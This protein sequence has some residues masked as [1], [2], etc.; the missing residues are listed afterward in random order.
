MAE[1]FISYKREDREWAEALSKLLESK[2]L[3][4][5]WDKRLS[6]GQD[7]DFVIDHEL[8]IADCV[9]VL[10]SIGSVKSRWV[11]AEANEGSARG[12]LV[13]VLIEDVRPPLAFRR[14]QTGSLI[15]WKKIADDVFERLYS[16]VQKVLHSF[17]ELESEKKGKYKIKPAVKD[18]SKLFEKCLSKQKK[19]IDWRTK[20]RD[21]NDPLK[22]S[23]QA[24][25]HEV[26]SRYNRMQIFGMT[27]PIS[28][29]DVF[30]DTRINEDLTWLQHHSAEQLNQITKQKAKKLDLQDVS[31]RGIKIAN[32]NKRLVVLGNPGGGTTT[33][34]IN[35]ALYTLAG[36]MEF[37][38]L[39]IFISLWS[40][41][42]AE[43]SLIDYI[44]NQ[45]DICNFPDAGYFITKMLE[46][47]NCLVLIDGYDLITDQ[48]KEIAQELRNFM[49][50][51]SEN[52]YILSSRI[53]AYDFAF[54]DFKVVEVANF[55]EK[56][57]KSYIGKW[58]AHSD[59]L[60][61]SCWRMLTNNKSLKEFVNKPLFLTLLCIAHDENFGLLDKYEELYGQAIRAILFRWDASRAIKRRTVHSN[62]SQKKVELLLGYLGEY[63]FQV[64]KLFMSQKAL[65]KKINEF[66]SKT[67]ITID[68]NP[69][70]DSLYVLKTIQ[71]NSG[72]L[73]ECA[74]NVFSFSHIALQEYFTAQYIIEEQSEKT[75][76]RENLFVPAW[77][78]V[79][80]ISAGML[81]SRSQSDSFVQLIR[82]TIS[83]FAH[84][85]EI[86]DLL[87][88]IFSV[89]KNESPYSASAN[90]ALSLH[91]FLSHVRF[92]NNKILQLLPALDSQLLQ[93]EI[94]PV[95]MAL[96][97]NR[98]QTFERIRIRNLNWNKSRALEN[99]IYGNQLLI[100]CLQISYTRKNVREEILTNLFLEE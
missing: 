87:N 46:C 7:F 48:K 78:E 30:V 55:S 71:E 20:R 29:M 72:L 60:R 28:L 51:Y 45:F 27:K 85:N 93:Y 58:F 84:E 33:F 66:F 9:V 22:L 61:D 50:R 14:I 77:R 89:V 2:G 99:Y 1:V 21:K 94:L 43:E 23:I 52:R 32:A 97:P 79:I 69:K 53:V 81:T 42:N 6:L 16:E 98:V 82:D 10:W 34:L 95:D 83:N 90:R 18:I 41:P 49:N 36:Q 86:Q 47:G 8:E 88:T 73:V 80:R 63:S 3:S 54:A 37:S 15:G 40:W 44:T 91:G 35:I 11:L 17:P 4:T 64:G 100:D 56:Q 25:S 38:A 59:K 57:I 62:L 70:T 24:Y 68:D 65:E 12:I 75:L 5:W 26:T 31:I 39:P 19:F 67:A 13:P 76:I 92:P 74:C 96:T